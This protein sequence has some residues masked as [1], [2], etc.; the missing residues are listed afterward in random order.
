MKRKLI[1]LFIVLC[2]AIALLAWLGVGFYS[3]GPAVSDLKAELESIYGTEYAGKAVENGT[4]DMVFAV[5]PKT[6]FLTNWNLRN[7]LGM[8]YEYQCKVIFTTYIEGSPKTVR[9]ITYRGTDPMGAAN[10]AERAKLD[11]DSKAETSEV[12]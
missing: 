11:L 1:V 8:D 2:L 4:E 12:K 6:W 7:A 3:S 9:T 10:V 5:E